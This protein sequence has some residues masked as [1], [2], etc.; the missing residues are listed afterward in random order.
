MQNICSKRAHL[1]NYC[2]IYPLSSDFEA[3][4]FLISLSK[5]RTKGKEEGIRLYVLLDIFFYFLLKTS[6]ENF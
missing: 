5:V 2:R 3:F 4:S 6:K 1:Q